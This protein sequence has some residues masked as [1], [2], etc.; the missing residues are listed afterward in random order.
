[1]WC[2]CATDFYVIGFFMRMAGRVAAAIE[3]ITDIFTQHRPASEALKDWGK[4]HRFAGEE[5]GRIS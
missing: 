1:M 3:I 4:S 5:S 2:G